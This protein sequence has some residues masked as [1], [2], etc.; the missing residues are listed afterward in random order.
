MHRSNPSGYLSLKSSFPTLKEQ[1][2][3]C[4]GANG[5]P[6]SAIQWHDRRQPGAKRGVSPLSGEREQGYSLTLRMSAIGQTPVSAAG[7]S[8]P[9]ATLKSHSDSAERPADNVPDQCWP[10]AR[11]SATYRN[12]CHN[13]KWSKPRQQV[14]ECV[15]WLYWN[16]TVGKGKVPWFASLFLTLE[17]GHELVPPF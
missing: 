14:T 8:A 3:L 12:K 4:P 13:R 15:P 6:G 5:S 10:V 1:K 9:P 16:G 7:W 2:Q 17:Q 11:S